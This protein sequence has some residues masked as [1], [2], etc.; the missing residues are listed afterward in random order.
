VTVL[1]FSL[2]TSAVVALGASSLAQTPAPS[3][4]SPTANVQIAVGAGV[5]GPQGAPVGTVAAVGADFVVV[6][7]DK[8]E[9][10]L[11]RDA[12]A[13]GPNGLVIGLSRDELNAATER[14][15]ARVNELMQPGANVFGAQGGTVGTIV[16]TEADLVTVKLAS[17][18]MVRLP[19]T[20]FAAGPKGLMI[21]L[22]VQQLEAQAAAAS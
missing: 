13:V 14:A 11:P 12:F 4:S 2:F 10:S 22:T 3:T 6:R 18:K 20:G 17:G 21:G 5:S 7:T 15:L 1:Q 16:S 8:H 19:K 9:A